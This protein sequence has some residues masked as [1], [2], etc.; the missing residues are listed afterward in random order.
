M[1]NGVGV[2]MRVWA[3][4]FAGFISF[5]AATVWSADAIKKAPDPANGERIATQICAACH[6]A[7]GNSAASANPHLA[8]QHA[9][10]LAKQLHDFKSNKDRKN[11]VMMG[12]VAPLSADDVRDVAAYYGAQ[13]PKPGFAQNK[14]LVALGQKLY[15]GGNSATG[16]PA[17]AACHGPDGSGLPSQY[18]RLAGQFAEYTASQLKA[19]RAGERANDANQM[20]RV[21]AAR[22]TDREVAAVAQYAAG[23][24]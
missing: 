4:G 21:I 1:C 7:D 13:K 6:G 15:R 20:M 9:E 19:F 24:R 11:A 16:V 8:G 10:Y 2:A 14:E 5:I 23:L 18:P 17:C 22:M 12:M 3:V